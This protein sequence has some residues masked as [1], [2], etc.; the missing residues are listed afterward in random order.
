[1]FFSLRHIKAAADYSHAAPSEQEKTS[2]VPPLLLWLHQAAVTHLGRT[3]RTP[4]SP[5]QALMTQVPRSAMDVAQDGS[6]PMD[7]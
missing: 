5:E 1:L 4:Q 3:S 6:R 2:P 7:V